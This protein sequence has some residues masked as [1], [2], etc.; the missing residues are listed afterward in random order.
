MDA[1]RFELGRPLPLNFLRR[2]SKAGHVDSVAHGLAKYLME[3]ALVEYSMAH[4]PP[5]IVAGT[6]AFRL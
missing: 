5:S 2:N 6:K 3:L 4:Y 1:L